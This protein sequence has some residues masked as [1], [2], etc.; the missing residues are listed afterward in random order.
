MLW[1]V[2]MTQAFLGLIWLDFLWSNNLPHDYTLCKAGE[3]KKEFLVSSM[4]FPVEVTKL[5]A[6]QKSIGLVCTYRLAIRA[7]S[8]VMEH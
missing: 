1:S 8:I 6:S 3:R 2:I 4:L 7:K 5:V